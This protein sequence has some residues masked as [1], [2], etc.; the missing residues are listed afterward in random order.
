MPGKLD[1]VVVV[2]R[3]TQFLPQ[4]LPVLGE[5]VSLADG[6]LVL[7]DNG[8][9]EDVSAELREH[10]TETN[11]T[12]IR[13]DDN[14]NY[15]AALNRALAECD[16]KAVLIAHS[17]AV[18]APFC[19]ERMLEKIGHYDAVLPYTN[20]S[21]VS[22]LVTPLSGGRIYNDLRTPAAT[23]R[24]IAVSLASD[25]IASVEVKEEGGC[26]DGID[27]FFCMVRREVI[28]VLGRFDETIFHHD[29]RLD[30]EWW[31]SAGRDRFQAVSAPG[32]FCFH[33]GGF[34][35]DSIFDER[36]VATR[37]ND[38]ILSR[39][40]VMQNVEGEG[41]PTADVLR[42]VVFRFDAELER[43]SSGPIFGKP[44]HLIHIGTPSDGVLR[45][46]EGFFETSTVLQPED[47]S[48]KYDEAIH[49]CQ[50]S[51]IFI[52][53]TG[54]HIHEAA[55]PGI[56]RLTLE[57]YDAI[58]FP[59]M[60]CDIAGEQVLLSAG[61]QHYPFSQIRMF[62]KDAGYSI[63][64]GDNPVRC[65]GESVVRSTQ[66]LPGEAVLQHIFQRGQWLGKWLSAVPQLPSVITG[67][68]PRRSVVTV[69]ATDDRL[70]VCIGVSTLD[71]KKP[72]HQ[73]SYMATVGLRDALT[74]HPNVLR[75]DCF[76]GKWQDRTAINDR[77][78]ASNE[79]VHVFVSVDE[80]RPAPS[81]EHCARICWL[82]TARF[83]DEFSPSQVAALG[84]DK[85]FTSSRRV[86]EE[87]RSIGHECD[88]L[89]PGVSNT[90]RQF[91]K[92]SAQCQIG[93]LVRAAPQDWDASS[94]VAA[95]ARLRDIDCR[96]FGYGWDNIGAIKHS[97][98]DMEHNR[99]ARAM[100]F[101]NDAIPLLGPPASI[102][103][104]A[105]IFGGMQCLLHIPSPTDA[106]WG[107]VPYSVCEA[108]ASG[109][110]AVLMDAKGTFADID[111][112][113]APVYLERT[114][115]EAAQRAVNIISMS[116]DDLEIL[117]DHARQWAILNNHTH[118]AAALLSSVVVHP[119]ERIPADRGLL[120][121]RLC[122]SVDQQVKDMIRSCARLRGISEIEF[123]D[124]PE[125][126]DVAFSAE[127]DRGGVL[128]RVRMVRPPSASQV[129]GILATL[130]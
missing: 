50:A 21:H 61:E 93:M 100:S 47:D 48:K 3:R 52:M 80:M 1:A 32:A 22:G 76:D 77:T 31:K 113:D 29:Y 98:S 102:K 23:N 25:V 53:R 110:P 85:Y 116:L 121:V 55:L 62:Q 114:P 56:K 7:V 128:L 34:T 115:A 120:S 107:F 2:Y 19:I 72:R 39:S 79:D 92:V 38:M 11:A 18:P 112:G 73:P 129:D 14:T 122:E 84:Y 71:L 10:A 17:D 88:F 63:V 49:G 35:M 59:F 96:I 41:G 75:V 57:P 40:G 74:S 27:T 119:G 28:G 87:L 106:E 15:G 42:N 99:R 13:F 26:V 9:D 82:T 97:I 108:L 111:F 68:S 46:Y 8:N 90:V 37:T 12:L 65:D 125:S 126:D 36:I 45:Q 4:L 60:R 95:L 91:I 103:Q 69:P 66:S 89:V 127:F 78:Y 117:A 67:D 16:S 104:E 81:L 118:K 30:S 6:R 94:L 43:G 64:P 86:C 54:E 24:T 44:I 123:A 51:W 105:A 20:C 101:L 109:K 5:A 124:E 58:E 83:V 70:C 33:Y 130:G